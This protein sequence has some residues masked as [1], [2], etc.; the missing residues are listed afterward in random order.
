MITDCKSAG[1]NESTN[2]LVAGFAVGEGDGAATGL[3]AIGEA[4]T[5]CAGRDAGGGGDCAK[6]FAPKIEKVARDNRGITVISRRY[7]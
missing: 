1:L 4:L 7:P 3:T 5:G 6:R 2:C